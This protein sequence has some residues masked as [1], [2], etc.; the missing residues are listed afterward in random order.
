MTNVLLALS[1]RAKCCKNRLSQC[2]MKQQ[3]WTEHNCHPTVNNPGLI[4]KYYEA[5]GTVFGRHNIALFPSGCWLWHGSSSGSSG[6]SICFSM[7]T[8]FQLKRGQKKQQQVDKCQDCVIYHLI[9]FPL[10]EITREINIMYQSHEIMSYFS[11]QGAW[12]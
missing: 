7:L 4:I 8:S 11:W 1:P 10:Q 2:I 6:K 9:F 12:I 3:V 5:L